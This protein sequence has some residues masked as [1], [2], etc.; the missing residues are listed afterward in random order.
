M[1]NA[2]EVKKYAKRDGAAVVKSAKQRI[3]TSDIKNSINLRSIRYDNCGTLGFQPHV[4]IRAD[5]LYE[6]SEDGW[7]KGKLTYSKDEVDAPA[8][9]RTV[10]CDIQAVRMQYD[11]LD[12]NAHYCLR[13]A[14]GTKRGSRRTQMLLAGKAVIH[15][16]LTMPQGKVRIFEF[17]VP[18]KTVASGILELTFKKISGLAAV[19]SEVWLLSDMQQP[20]LRISVES[21]PCGTLMVRAAD[22]LRGQCEGAEITV[23]GPNDLSLQEK[24]SSAGVALIDLSKS[25]S[26]RTTGE[27]TVTV[28][29]DQTATT[30]IVPIDRLFFRLPVLTPIPDRVL[31]ASR[32]AMSLCGTWRFAVAPPENFANIELDDSNWNLINVPGEWVIQGFTVAKNTAAGYRRQF[33]V[34]ADWTGKRVKLR[35]DA[36]YSDATVWINGRRAGHHMGGF[37]PFELDI[38]DLIRTGRENKIALAVK[39]ESLA[40]NKLT[41]FGNTSAPDSYAAHPLG[42]ISRKITLFVVPELSVSSLHV[43]TTFDKDFHDATLRVMLNITNQSGR[44]V[45]NVKVRLELTDPGKVSVK[46][47]PCVVKLPTVKA[48]QTLEHVIEI[49]VAAPAKWDAEHPNLYVV[50]CRLDAGGNLLE[51]VSRRF[52]FRQVEIHGNQLFVNNLPVKLRGVARHDTHAIQGWSLTPEL[53]RKDAELFRDANVNHVRTILGLPTEEFIDAC[54]ELGIFVEEEAPFHHAQYIINPEYRQATLMH[55]AEMLQRDLSHPCIIIWSLM[56]EAMWSSNFEASGELIR[57]VD[58]TRPR[59]SNCSFFDCYDYKAFPWME[60]NSWHYPGPKGPARAHDAEKPTSFGEYCH[61]NL[62]NREE[63]VTDPGLRDYW[64]R[65]LAPMWEKMFT[66]KGCL[67]GSIFAGVDEI[68][69]LPNKEVGW[70]AWGALIDCWKRT[71]PEY[72][73]VKKTYSPVRIIQKTIPLPA[74]G[75]SIQLKVANRHDFTNLN[76]LEIKWT[77]GEESGTVTADVPPRSSGTISIRPKRTDL[78]GQKLSVKFYSPRGFLINVYQLPIGKP[79]QLA[80]VKC[81]AT[82]TGKVKLIQSDDTITIKANQSTWIF[83]HKTGMIQE[84][85]FGNRTMLIGGPVLMV[86]PLKV[87]ARSSICQKHSADIPPFNAACTQWQISSVKAGQTNEGVEIRVNGQ[88]EEAVGTYTMRIDNAGQLTVQYRFAYQDK[89]NPRQIGIV[90]NLPET[91]DTLAW[92]RMTQWTVYSPGHI[93]RPAGHAK[94]FRSAKWP[95]IKYRQEPPWPW[96]LDS[97]ALGTNDFR[98]TR[99]NIL[100]TSLR[101]SNGYG[102]LVRSDGTQHARAWVDSNRIRL[103]VAGYYTGGAEPYHASH[104]VDERKPLKKGSVLEDCVHL[105]LVAD[106]QA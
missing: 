65:I 60:I 88:Y 26:S 73:H 48:G 72:W 61:T 25:V 11:N 38:T 91:C 39:K 29:T 31:G 32:Q 103:L 4:L 76:E 99:N 55:T 36:V 52:G 71:K 41:S 96:A 35:C 20:E 101:A 34:P 95:K 69:M 85:Q 100:W 58:P 82:A 81:G 17:D 5:V 14:Y 3:K 46:I 13:V 21:G 87:P 24:T 7:T 40:D 6:K 89:I 106:E 77:I 63:N 78:A 70:G 93:G 104:L 23:T 9:S 97:N 68:Q 51:K 44:D 94:A 27:L 47:A 74:S 33:T 42:G 83:N 105:E 57:K 28:R 49:H 22:G 56:N 54:D 2:K 18:S 19:V 59:L 30:R 67:G 80:E 86:L 8:Q 15:D 50:T 37:T 102:L 12:P 79:P 98:A 84:A 64:G 53:C 66:S 45:Q 92:K 10:A 16:E 43:A 75:A 1:L 62:Y 90:F